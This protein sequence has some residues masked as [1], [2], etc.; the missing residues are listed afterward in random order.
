MKHFIRISLRVMEK[1][2]FWGVF[3]LVLGLGVQTGLAGQLFFEDFSG[4]LTAWNIWHSSTTPYTFE[5]TGNDGNPAPSLLLDDR[6]NNGCYAVSKQTFTYTNAVTE[7]SAD[8][9]QG[10]AAF[11]DQRYASLYVSKVNH[12][13]YDHGLIR[14]ST[15]AG[16]NPN[17]PNTAYCH[18][19]YEEDGVEQ[20]EQSDYI[21]IPSGDGWHRATIKIL[22][23]GF[24]EF[25]IDQQL[26]YTSLHPVSDAYDGQTAVMVGGRKS[27]YDNVEVTQSTDEQA[28]QIDHDQYLEG[29]F[30]QPDEVDV[31]T[32]HGNQGERITMRMKMT[33]AEENIYHFNPRF[34][35]LDPDGESVY[36]AKSEYKHTV[37]TVR[38]FVLPKSGEYKVLA[39]NWRPFQVGTYI[40]SLW[41]WERDPVVAIDHDQ[42]LEDQELHYPIDHDLYKFNGNAGERI[43]LRVMMTEAANIYYFCPRFE[44]YAPDGQLVTVAKSSKKCYHVQIQDF[45]LEQTGEYLVRL[46][47]WSSQ[48]SGK[49]RISLWIWERDPVVAIDH[50]QCLEEQVINYP[51]DKNLYSFNASA[52]DRIFIKMRMTQAQNIY[53]FN[54]RFE[55]YGPDGSLVTVAQSRKKVYYVHLQDFVLPADGQYI[56]RASNWR[57]NYGGQYR[58]SLWIWEREEVDPITDGQVLE[59]QEIAYIGDMNLYSFEAFEGDKITLTMEMTQASSNR[60]YFNPRFELY[61]PDGELVT[62][63]KS[64]KKVK[65][66][67]L[68]D[69][70]VNKTGVYLVRADNWQENQTGLYQ[71]SLG[72][73]SN[74]DEIPP[75]ISGLEDIVRDQ[76]SDCSELTEIDMPDIAVTDNRDLFPTIVTEFHYADGRQEVRESLPLSVELFPIG[77]STVI[78]SATDA[79]ENPAAGSFTV[80]VHSQTKLDITAAFMISGVSEPVS[81]MEVRAFDASITS[82][83]DLAD[84]MPGNGVLSAFFHEIYFSCPSVSTV[85]LDENGHAEMGMLPGNYVVITGVDSNENN[86]LDPNDLFFGAQVPGLQCG[87]TRPLQLTLN[88]MAIYASEDFSTQPK[89]EVMGDCG[90]AGESIVEP[91]CHVTGSVFGSSVCLKNRATVEG[92]VLYNEINM[93][94][95]AVVNGELIS[96]LPA[97]LC[98]PTP[99]LPAFEAG[100]DNV[101]VQK[102]VTKVLEAGDYGSIKLKSGPKNDPAVLQLAGG[103]YNL[104]KIEIGNHARIECLGACEIR[105]DEDLLMHNDAYFG[106]APETNVTAGDITVFVMGTN[107]KQGNGNSAPKSAVIGAFAFIQAKVFAPNSMLWFKSSA[108][109]RGVFAGKFVELDQ[110]VTVTLED[111]SLF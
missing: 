33:W 37:V 77:T 34:D 42:C 47:N 53:H 98:D 39:S 27:L 2:S 76:A 18:L 93:H 9:K 28:I 95:K 29:R 32:F 30:D 81:G 63:A 35:I 20:I 1:M 52:G 66:V 111:G 105:I 88:S 7:V 79:A 110:S 73:V 86:V 78:I 83:A 11:S 96:P 50:D 25:Y 70:E 43:T 89:A 36:V 31:Y 26:V 51:I 3:V 94:N 97:T 22:D 56:I 6:L 10:N 15:I 67:S 85:I 40:L 24:V 82:C 72:I 4:D 23:T 62:V 12:Y 90:A 101:T 46:D 13:N 100:T 84:G 54:P 38:D 69:F 14:L 59:N 55:I 104:Q 5:I 91:N 92:D 80:T 109:G 44:V 49:Y 102:G 71:L 58:I 41:I 65:T 75:V 48:F 106:S 61:D 87:E 64:R 17:Y 8:I 103:V 99:P 21:P 68:A 45:V 19:F 57:E 74:R 16:T 108:D 107:A 60:W